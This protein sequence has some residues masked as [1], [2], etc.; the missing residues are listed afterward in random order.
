MSFNSFTA[1]AKS[2]RPSRVFLFAFVAFITTTCITPAHA[3]VWREALPQ[4]QPLGS[5]DLRWFGLRVYT[6]NLWSE[7]KPFD[8]SAPFAL[9]LTYHLDISRQRFVDTSIDEI[10]RLSGNRL[11]VEKLKHWEREMSRAF[12]DVKAGDQL[13]GVYLPNEGCRF[14][15]RSKLLAD[16]RDPE[17]ANAFFAIW[18]DERSRKKELRAQL[19]GVRK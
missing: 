1:R 8:A 9:E 11:P 19:L 12:T 17:F 3:T 16:I 14:Y 4:A 5:G 2:A 18:L 13:I 7:R 10:R 6:A 15:S